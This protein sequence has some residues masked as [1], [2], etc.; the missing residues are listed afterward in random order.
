MIGKNKYVLV[1]S[2]FYKK[3]IKL[4]KLTVKNPAIS[5]KSCTD[6]CKNDE[7]KST[8]IKIYES[9]FNKQKTQS[10]ELIQTISD[11]IVNPTEKDVRQSCNCLTG[12][13]K[14]YCPCKKNK[15]KCDGNCHEGKRC[16]N[17]L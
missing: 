10:R 16:Y 14:N 17:I 9:E 13:N 5:P 11:N 7:F 8:I 4:K 12:C 2:A 3:I 6:N 1:F 15:V